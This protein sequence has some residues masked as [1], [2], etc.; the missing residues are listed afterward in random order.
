MDQV[1]NSAR[2][3]DARNA[4]SDHTLVIP[5]YNRPDLLRRLV[6]YYVERT[7]P[8]N[9]LVLD[10][11]AP[12]I[13]AQNAAAL[14]AYGP[15]LRHIVYP[16]TTPMAAK[17]ARGLQEVA[18]PTV[19]FCADDDLVFTEALQQARDFLLQNPDY[20]CAHGLYLNF[21]EDGLNVHVTR[22]YAGESNDAEHAGARIFRLCQNYE[23]LFYGVFRTG[24]LQ[25]IFAEAAK[26]SSLHYQELFQSAAA[27]IIGKVK[28]FPSFYA[29][30]R[31]GPEAEPGRD[32]WQTYYW[33]AD[34]PTD[35]LTHYSDYRERTAAFYV[36]HSGEGALDRDAFLRVLDITHAMYFSKG[37]PPA[38]FHDRLKPYWPNDAF[39]KEPGDLF[40]A[41]R[42]GPVKKKWTRGERF[43]IKVWRRLRASF[44]HKPDAGTE[45]ERQIDLMNAQIQQTCRMPWQCHLSRDLKWAA[46]RPDFRAAYR[47]LCAYLDS[48]ADSHGR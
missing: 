23:S 21:R 47:E 32:K 41:M 48:I 30:R 26:I 34:D 1:V 10:S 31:S 17:L 7:Q 8:P 20:V 35:F 15:S 3:T 42:S 37:C 24:D 4:L 36:G 28:R 33:F 40:Q 6:T 14:A 16:S 2:E 38:Y 25:S 29:A 13:A 45:A 5:T 43:T 19:S 18:T 46:G 9:L 12:D 27:L 44:G 22:E 39:V 11:S